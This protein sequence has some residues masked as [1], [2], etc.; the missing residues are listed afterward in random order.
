MDISLFYL[1]PVREITVAREHDRDCLPFN[2]P[3][4]TVVGRFMKF[5]NA[6]L[7][8]IARK[9][10]AAGCYGRRNTGWRELG[11]GFVPDVRT[12]K[13]FSRGFKHWMVAELHALTLPS[14]PEPAPPEMNPRPLPVS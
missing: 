6:R 5:Y 1:G 14:C 9:R 7:A 12:L 8:H 3:V 10:R 4:D 2:G 13:S 11:D